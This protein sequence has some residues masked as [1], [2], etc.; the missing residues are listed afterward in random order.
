MLSHS[1]D[2]KRRENSYGLLPSASLS[3]YSVF[4]SAGFFVAFSFFL[5]SFGSRRLVSSVLLMQERCLFVI[6]FGSFFPWPRVRMCNVV[7]FIVRVWEFPDIKSN[8]FHA[9]MALY[10]DYA[11][12]ATCEANRKVL[13]GHFKS[14]DSFKFRVLKVG[15]EMPTEAAGVKFPGDCYGDQGC[16]C[17][18]GCSIG[19]WISRNF[20]VR[21]AT[22]TCHAE[23]RCKNIF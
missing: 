22:R 2:G 8:F 9:K 6:S 16:L 18:W 23:C 15:T 3:I 19:S 10:V 21:V 5:L 14:R 17:T 20:D 4:F 1:S 12:T 7:A 11:C 13:G